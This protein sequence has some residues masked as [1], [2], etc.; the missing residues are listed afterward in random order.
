MWR[1]HQ[2]VSRKQKSVRKSLCVSSIP[3]AEER[4]K[5]RKT[6]YY[7]IINSIPTFWIPS[8][9]YRSACYRSLIAISKP[10]I[11]AKTSTKISTR[12]E[13]T[14]PLLPSA[15]G[16]L[17]PICIF[18]NKGRKKI[19]GSWRKPAKNEN[20]ETEIAVRNKAKML[21]DESMILKIG[22]YN[23]GEWLDFVAKEVHYHHQSKRKYLHKKDKSSKKNPTISGKFVG[24]LK[25]VSKIQ[26]L[27]RKRSQ[28]INYNVILHYISL[29]IY[30]L[31]IPICCPIQK[32]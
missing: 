30:P 11:K 2:A 12:S 22:N 21:N 31:H 32:Q 25:V 5:K 24:C 7:Q 1:K 20:Y 27:V 23:F 14:S 8:Y 16:V 26:Q 18:C 13:N 3:T 9:G 15:T 19:G 17:T 4:R 10:K 6:K 28:K 29:P